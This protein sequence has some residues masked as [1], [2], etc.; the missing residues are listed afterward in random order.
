VAL[1]FSAHGSQIMAGNPDIMLFMNRDAGMTILTKLV[2]MFDT[3][4]GNAIEKLSYTD[5]GARFGVSRTHVRTLLHDA[6]QAG[7][8]SLSG[9]GGRFVELKPAILRAFDRFIADSMSGHD[10][11]HRIALSRMAGAGA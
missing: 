2:Q 11:L 7:L 10:L 8:V 3:A 6:E 4:G 5:I 9:Q 1:G